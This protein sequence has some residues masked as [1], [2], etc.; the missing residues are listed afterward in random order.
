MK[1]R[2]GGVNFLFFFFFFFFCEKNLNQKA[3]AEATRRI[4][5]RHDNFSTP[6]LEVQKQRVLLQHECTIYQDIAD[7]WGMGMNGDEWG[8]KFTHSSVGG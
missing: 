1:K 2:G 4:S 3:G 5:G 8:S 7:E 6:T